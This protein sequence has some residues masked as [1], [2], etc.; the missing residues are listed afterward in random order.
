MSD[1]KPPLFSIISI[2]FNEENGIRR[3][4]ESVVSQ[5]YRDYE[6][7]VV[8]GGSTD[9]TL[10]ILKE[11]SGSITR[12]IS[13]PDEGIYDAM[14]KGIKMASGE[15]LVFLNGGDFFASDDV[16]TDVSVA[17]QKELIYGDIFFD[18]VGGT[19]AIYPDVMSE[20]YLLK[21]MAPHQA[22]FFRHD[23]FHRFGNYDRSYKIAADY[24]L[25]V[26]LIE[27]GK[28]SYHYIARPLSV[29]DRSGISS[30]PAHRE[31]RKREN[32]R[33]RKQYFRRY[34]WSLKALR[35]EVKN[36]LRKIWDKS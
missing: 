5:D 33:V 28:V 16:L 23:L 13:E 24:E 29:F 30:G 8:D 32:H 6:W 11:F 35:Q 20:G 21:K 34:R 14:N 36:G 27:V 10:E 31:L 3:T 26:R 2:C 1:F 19:L 12:M 7:I 9:G 15:Y 25:Y 17:P 4:C 22:T 18:E